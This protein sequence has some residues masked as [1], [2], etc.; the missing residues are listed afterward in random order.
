[1]HVSAWR[2]LKDT[3]QLLQDSVS[4]LQSQLSQVNSDKQ[5]LLRDN[6]SL[7]QE[8]EALRRGCVGHIP[9]L[10]SVRLCACSLKYVCVPPSPSPRLPTLKLESPSPCSVAAP[11]APASPRCAAVP[12]SSPS[13]SSIA[14]D[15][16]AGAGPASP[17]VFA[18][19]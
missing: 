6:T 17:V 18:A 7:R 13:T 15:E 12:P 16:P 4:A 11:L 8:L 10:D 2:R 3:L 1:M 9:P 19:P 5:A 14:Q